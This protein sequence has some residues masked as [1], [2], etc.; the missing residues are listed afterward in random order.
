MTRT[1]T[2]TVPLVR[3]RMVDGT[4]WRLDCDRSRCPEHRTTTTS[5]GGARQF[6]ILHR[7]PDP[8]ALVAAAL[9]EE[10]RT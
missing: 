4:T 7:A 5:P 2:A 10:V 6:A 3:V 8:D 9:A 1:R